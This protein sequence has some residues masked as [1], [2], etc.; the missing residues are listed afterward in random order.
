MQDLNRLTHALP[1]R[2]RPES[3][4]VN[5]T[6]KSTRR[7]AK[8]PLPTGGSTARTLV[9]RNHSV[10]E[11]QP[12]STHGSP[13]DMPVEPPC[14]GL[15]SPTPRQH[16]PFQLTPWPI[17]PNLWWQPAEI[18]GL[19][20]ND[21]ADDGYGIN[22]IGFLPTS[23]VANARVKH[24]K[25]QIAEWKS[26]EAKEARQ[27]RVEMRRESNIQIHILEENSLKLDGKARKVRFSEPQSYC[28]R[29]KCALNMQKGAADVS[30]S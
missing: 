21:P 7:K 18:T 24:R 1:K 27:K 12:V 19:H 11:Q 16:P 3:S 13:K 6:S 15:G 9:F 8:M 30:T 10:V 26:R 14:L 25:R 20:H 2:K 22:G 17:S 28:S 29:S 23:A 4:F 5:S